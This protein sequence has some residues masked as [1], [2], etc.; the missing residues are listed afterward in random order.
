MVVWVC[1]HFCFDFKVSSDLPAQ[2][3]PS[4]AGN[5]VERSVHKPLF[6]QCGYLM[7]IYSASLY[8]GRLLAYRQQKVPFEEEQNTLLIGLF[9][10]YVKVN[11]R[12]L[13]YGIDH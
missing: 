12:S 4:I 9:L 1:W 2:F 11:W 7:T 10:L 13:K 6:W 8:Y 5:K 3:S